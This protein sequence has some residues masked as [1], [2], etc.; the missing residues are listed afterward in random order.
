MRPSSPGGGPAD[1]ARE[2]G[3]PTGRTGPGVLRPKR[4]AER[5]EAPV[6]PVGGRFSRDASPLEPPPGELGRA[7][8]SIGCQAGVVV[9]SGEPTTVVTVSGSKGNEA[10]RSVRS[11][12]KEQLG[13]DF[14]D[15]GFEPRAGN[16]GEEIG[17]VHLAQHARGDAHGG[18]DF[19]DARLAGQSVL[20][21]FARCEPDGKS[22]IT[23]FPS[24]RR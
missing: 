8:S 20:C 21:G 13:N 19:A 22:Q 11:L 2:G 10:E 6:L 7:T 18:G 17:F 15:A 3:A 14:V 9:S 4:N 24:L 5:R 23:R 16:Y 1:E 12:R